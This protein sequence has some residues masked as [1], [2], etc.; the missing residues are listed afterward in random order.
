MAISERNMGLENSLPLEAVERFAQREFMRLLPHEHDS[1]Y[2]PMLEAYICATCG[3]ILA[4]I[5]RVASLK[6]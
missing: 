5:E 4:T 6:D 1:I 2:E 3:I